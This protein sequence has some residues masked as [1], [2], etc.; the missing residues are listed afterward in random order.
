VGGAVDVFGAVW[1][2]VGPYRGTQ[3][4]LTKIENILYTVD[5]FPLAFREEKSRCGTV[6]YGI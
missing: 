4:I 2:C 6:F 1:G 3:K 5:G